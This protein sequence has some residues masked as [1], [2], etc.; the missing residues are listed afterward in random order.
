[1]SDELCD[2]L[3]DELKIAY[4]TKKSRPT[5]HCE[6][7]KGR[8]NPTKSPRGLLAVAVPSRSAKGEIATLRSR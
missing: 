6:P 2:E 5:C 4:G 8:G 3:S 1:M 7:R